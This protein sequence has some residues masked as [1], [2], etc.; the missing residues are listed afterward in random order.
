MT[1]SS[2]IFKKKNKSK[3]MSKETTTTETVDQT[4]DTTTT[5]TGA[6]TAT[7]ENDPNKVVLLGSI[8]YTNER[9]YMDWLSKMDASQA[10]FVLVASANFSQAKGVYNLAESELISSA[11]RAIKNN[12]TDA[13][14][15]KETTTP[16]AKVEKK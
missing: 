7:P 10:I 8:S 5:A 12:S 6:E 14:A 4:Q 2:K 15:A 13:T 16:K 1:I 11:I 3:V 9:E